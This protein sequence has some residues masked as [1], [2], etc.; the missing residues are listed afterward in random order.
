MRKKRSGPARAA[1]R[2]FEKKG[3]RANV[4]ASD[5]RANRMKRV[6]T[7]LVEEAW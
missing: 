2:A 6:K 3:E 4:K 1:M 5:A 7:R